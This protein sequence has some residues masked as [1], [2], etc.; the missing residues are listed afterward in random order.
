MQAAAAPI[1]DAGVHDPQQRS[2]DDD[3]DERGSSRSLSHCNLEFGVH[4]ATGSPRI[5]A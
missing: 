2:L 1:P 3:D 4:D 5:R